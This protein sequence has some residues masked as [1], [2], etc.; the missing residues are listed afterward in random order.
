MKSFIISLILIL[1]YVGS[2][3][4]AISFLISK[5]QYLNYIKGS[6]TANETII[7][8][9]EFLLEFPKM[10][11]RED[12]EKY[13]INQ[14]QDNNILNEPPQEL[15]KTEDDININGTYRYENLRIKLNNKKEIDSIV[16]VDYYSIDTLKTVLFPRISNIELN[17]GPNLMGNNG[18][19]IL[20]QGLIAIFVVIIIITTTY[21]KITKRKLI[22]NSL[23][24][25]LMSILLLN[26]IHFGLFQIH[27]F[28]TSATYLTYESFG[29][30]FLIMPSRISLNILAD[31]THKYADVFDVSVVCIIFL[32]VILFKL[33]KQKKEV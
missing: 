2:S 11:T 6:R 22:Q 15:I 20:W 9:E 16:I 31:H 29:Q 5:K 17:L 33:L 13:W 14:S 7:D 1:L 3:F 28:Y 32:S 18:L 21:Y 25:F 8:L 4:W 19:H 12:I 30:R 27:E 23:I 26:L 10:K 24:V